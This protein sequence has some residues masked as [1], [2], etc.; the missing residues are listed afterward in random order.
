MAGL[1]E[2]V[3]IIGAGPCGL[4]CAREFEQL[5]FHHWSLSER[6]LYP[7]GKAASF[8]DPQGFTWDLGGHV[9]FSHFGEFDALLTESMGDDV[10]EHERSSFIR[11]GDAWVP[12]P[13]Q[14]NLRHLPREIAL[15][16]LLGLI[17]APGANG[18]ANFRDWMEQ[19]FGDGITRHFMRPYNRKVWATPAEDMSAAW[20]AERVSVVDYRNALRNVVLGEDDI[21]WGPN[22]TFLFPKVGGTGEIY[23]RLAARLD[24]RL[25][26]G[27]RLVRLDPVK[28]EL[29]FDDGTVERADAVVSTAPIDVLVDSL[30]ECPQELA[31]AARELRRTSVSVAGI[32]YDRPLHD[33][34]SWLYFPEADTPCYRVTNFAKY[35]PANVPESDTGRYSSY[36]TESAHVPGD[37]PDEELLLQRVRA[38]LASA[39]LVGD[40]D[41]VVSEHVIEVD[42]AY[43]VPTL[44]RDRALTTIQTWLEEHRIFSR[45]RFGSWRYEIGNMDHAVKMGI[46]IARRLVEQRPEELW[47]P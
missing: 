17:A 27:R 39:G 7:G 30:S 13:F 44:G 11:I 47:T 40:D 1:P 45:G 36:L 14:N 16:C 29:Q 18:Q 4:A 3:A 23:R 25:T 15:E 8:Q 35:S 22:N 10:Y 43:P 32:G 2:H 5:G 24:D 19:T 46:D 6:E 33:D 34:R 9:V 42:Y 41:P 38:G 21:G 20:I 31:A 37:R 28:L 12:Y 26:L